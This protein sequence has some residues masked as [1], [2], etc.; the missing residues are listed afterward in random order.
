MYNQALMS[1]TGLGGSVAQGMQWQQ[2]VDTTAGAYALPGAT[3]GAVG[4]QRNA[5]DA[6]LAAREAQAKANQ[7]VFQGNAEVMSGPQLAQALS[8]EGRKAAIVKHGLQVP[9]LKAL[10][11]LLL[12][13]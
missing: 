4:L 1:T 7:Q 9:N 8:Q 11:A 12:Q 2:Q 3:Q 5:T 13:G 6:A 10:G